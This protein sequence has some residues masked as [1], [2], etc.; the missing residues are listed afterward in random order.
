VIDAGTRAPASP[1]H[2]RWVWI[3]LALAALTRLLLLARGAGASHDE[4]RIGTNGLSLLHGELPIY[5]AGQSFMGTAADVYLAGVGY[6]LLGVAPSTL[7]LVGVLLS[8]TWVGLVVFLAWVAWGAT[9]AAFTAAW[10]AVPP[11]FVLWWAQESRPH[12][13]LTLVLGVLS[14]LLARRVPGDSPPAASRR[15]LVLGLVIGLGYWTNP[16]A[17]VYCPAVLLYLVAGRYRPRSIPELILPL[18]GFGLGA[19]PHLLHAIPRG[20]AGPPLPGSG[21]PGIISHLASLGRAWPILLGVPADLPDWG[22][23]LLAAL[24]TALYLGLAGAAIW[25]GRAS[26]RRGGVDLAALGLV[27]AA[28]LGAVIVGKYGDLLWPRAFYLSPIW[29]ALPALAGAGLAALTKRRLAVVLAGLLMAI[30]AIGIGRGLLRGE[31][32]L[33]D[34]ALRELA[35]RAV[36]RGLAEA[37]ARDG[38]TRLYEEHHAR[39]DL[40]FVSRERVILSHYYEEALPRYARAVDGADPATIAW[41]VDAPSPP[42]AQ[43]LAALGA[44]FEYR[45]YPPLGGAYARFAVPPRPL[46]ELDPDSLRA[47]AS[48]SA[49]RAAWTLDRD[50]ATVWRTA[51]PM[52]GGEWLELDLGAVHPVALVRWLPRVYEETPVGLALEVSLDRAVWRRLLDVPAYQGP[53]YWSAGHPLGRVRSGRVELRIP[54]TPARYVRLVQTGTSP[55]WPWSISELFVYALDPAAPPHPAPWRSG[56]DLAASLARAGVQRLYADHGW[57]S[58][59]ALADPHLRILPANLHLDPYGWDG[60]RAELTPAVVWTP[61]AG[62]LVEPLDAEGVARIAAAAGVPLRREP[63]GDLVL[64]QATPAPPLAGRPLPAS[65]LTLTASLHPETTALALDGQRTTRWATG[66]PQTPGDWLRVDLRAPAP[67][68]ALR[69]WTLTPLDGPRGLALEGSPDGLAWHPLAARVSTEGE[70][71]WGGIALLRSGVEAVR[72]DFP[73]PLRAL[74]VTSP[75]AT[76]SRLVRPR[77]HPLRRVIRA[78][79]DRTRAIR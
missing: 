42:L 46:R 44:T 19:F 71:R 75:A 70:L 57:G 69:L 35:P 23:R 26:S 50:A 4:A 18:L 76:P 22:S 31:A 28:N 53:L 79:V 65:A 39:R 27:I 41:W 24:L 12:Y 72:L 51:G 32:P 13:H 66:R 60:P 73:H 34:P 25:R 59:A 74:R 11:D 68:R 38:I 49:P 61:G 47:A 63:L 58:A 9:G 48:E 62:A 54:P 6:V 7:E 17:I 29:T 55:R 15:L 10:L 64:F 8:I 37:L 14:L 67:L 56:A 40:A 1:K 2:A 52:R 36:Q 45:P 78:R 20:G 77:T 33:P 30:H 21:V 5:F 3:F 16:L 43:S